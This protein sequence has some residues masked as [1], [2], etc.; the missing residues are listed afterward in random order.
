MHEDDEDLPEDGHEVDKEVEAVADKV[1]VAHATLGDDHLRVP[2]DE[3]A[4]DGKADPQLSLHDHHRP[5]EEISEADPEHGGEG[6][7]E[8]A[9]QVQVLSVGGKDGGAAETREH[10]GGQSQRVGHDLRV[11]HHGDVE[12]G[13]H[14]QARAEGE[15]HEDAQTLLPVLA[16]VVGGRVKPN[17]EAQRGQSA[18]NAAALQQVGVQVDKRSESRGHQ[19]QRQRAVD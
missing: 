12:Q 16:V 15:S 7:H 6:R 18:Q 2:D 11:H 1:R 9:A 8:E 10:D 14:G 3:A 5:E 13:A 17:E 4:K 19:G